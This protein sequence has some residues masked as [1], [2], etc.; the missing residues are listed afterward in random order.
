MD[1]QTR[2]RIFEP[3]FT[4]KP[5]GIGTGLGLASVKSVIESLGGRIECE[6]ELGVGTRFRIELPL[7][8]QTQLS[9]GFESSISQV[10]VRFDRRRVLVV[11]DQV[12][13][14]AVVTATLQA[15]GAQVTDAGNAQAG[16]TLAEQ[17]EQPFELLWTDVVMP[18][19]GGGSLVAW[20]AEHSPRTKIVVCTGYSD[21]ELLRRDIALGRYELVNKPFGREEVLEACERALRG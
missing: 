11:D 18:Q 5:V 2:A 1:A 8:S 15:A 7:L 14:R 19:G 4:T 13:V 16:I 6:S 17:A 21:D 3:F 12:R 9:E 20:F 10:G